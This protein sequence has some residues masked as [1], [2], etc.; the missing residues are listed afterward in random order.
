MRT[1]ADRLI[2][3]VPSTGFGTGHH[4]STRLCLD[5]L[6]AFPVSG[7]TVLDVGTGSGVLA[8]AAARLGAADVTAIDVDVD[9][10]S[11]ARE[12]VDLNGVGD[13]VVLREVTLADASSLGRSFDL[14]LANLTGG[15]LMREAPHFAPLAAPGARLIASGFQTDESQDVIRA[16]DLAGWTLATAGAEETWVAGTFTRR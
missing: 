16:L 11:N 14:I 3:I 4:A 2:T 7:L 6:Q 5:H 12:N 10:L 1:R 8:I 9:A 13:R 15:H